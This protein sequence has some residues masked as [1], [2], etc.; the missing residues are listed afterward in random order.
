M[1]TKL[2]LT[3]LL[4]ISLLTESCSEKKEPV[5]GSEMD[6]MINELMQRMTMEEKIGQLNLL[7][8][9][10]DIVTGEATSSEI[11]KK[12]LE[13]RVGAVFNVRTLGKIREMQRIAVEESRNKIPLMFGLDVIH[14]YR[15]VF[16]IPLAWRQVLIWI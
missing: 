5:A 10:E 1:K 6:A 2:I 4:L 9:Y 14:G 16:P 7:P 3:G 15:T 13:G 12:I 8:G 11:G